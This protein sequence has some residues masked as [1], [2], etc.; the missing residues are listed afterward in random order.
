MPMP[1]DIGIIDLMLG[2]PVSA[3]NSEQYEFIKKKL[4]DAQS[5]EMFKMPV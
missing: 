4:M 3:D 5:K 1:K 2:I